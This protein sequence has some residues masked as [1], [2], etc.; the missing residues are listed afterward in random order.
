[1]LISSKHNCQTGS[2]RCRDR[3]AHAL[4]FREH[5]SLWNFSALVEIS[6]VLQHHHRWFLHLLSRRDCG[7]PWMG[8]TWNDHPKTCARMVWDTGR[9]TAV[10]DDMLRT[11]FRTFLC[12]VGS[13]FKD[14]R[15]GLWLSARYKIGWWWPFIMIIRYHWNHYHHRPSLAI[16]RV[17]HCPSIYPWKVTSLWKA[18]ASLV[19]ASAPQLTSCSLASPTPCL[20]SSGALTQLP[21]NLWRFFNGFVMFVLCFVCPF[22]G[23]LMP[24]HDKQRNNHVAIGCLCWT[25]CVLAPA[26]PHCSAPHFSKFHFGT[27]QGSAFA[28]SSGDTGLGPWPQLVSGQ[29]H[30]RLPLFHRCLG[31]ICIH[32][33]W[34]ELLG[35]KFHQEFK[36]QDFD[37]M[38][39][40]CVENML[41]KLVHQLHGCRSYL[42]VA[43]LVWVNPLFC[44]D[45]P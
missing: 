8:V 45:L 27:A 35:C 9:T 41:V 36:S 38:S 37:I 28:I 40:S 29:P 10:K 12:I 18:V 31:T 32:L 6:Q 7:E 42:Y 39:Q 20:K 43:F 4:S 21:N 1:M 24:N 22:W 30:I 25:L 3:L 14:W 33:Q 13:F 26:Q 34:W 16:I 17:I 2:T 5:K 15:I 23:K 44:E 19:A 11:V